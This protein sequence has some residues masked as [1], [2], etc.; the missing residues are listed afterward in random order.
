MASMKG[1]RSAWAVLGVI[2]FV[3]CLAPLL[4][5]FSQLLSDPRA[6]EGVLSVLSWPRT[7][8]LL[9]RSLWLAAGT[10]AFALV[11]GVPLAVLLFSL[12]SRATGALLLVHLFPLFLPP[13]LMALGWHH[14][15]GP[16]E[17]GR[18]RSLFGPLASQWGFVVIV[19]L[20]YLPAATGLT[21]LGL[22]GVDRG[23]E[24]AALVDV[25]PYRTVTRVLLPLAAPAVALAGLV[26]F[27]L[28]LSELGVASFLRITTYQSLVLS[29]L[30]GVAFVPGQ[31][32]GLLVPLMVVGVGLLLVE[33]RLIGRGSFAS[34]G[35]SLAGRRAYDF[36]GWALPARLVLWGLALLPSLPLVGLAWRSGWA[37]VVLARGWM[38]PSLLNSFEASFWTALLAVSVGLVAGHGLARGARFAGLVDASL[39]LG[40]LVPGTVM[41]V[42]VVALW[43]HPATQFVYG[44]TAVLVFGLAS[45]T[46]ILAS[47]AVAVS[48]SHRPVSPEEA[49]L[50]VDGS[51]WRVLGRIVAPVNARWI[52]AGWLLAMVFAMRELAAVV[53]FYPPGGDPLP[54]RIFTLEANGPPRVVAGLAL[55]HVAA[56]AAVVGLGLALVAQPRRWDGTMRRARTRRST[57]RRAAQ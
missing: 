7:W 17:L 56:T 18:G 57:S 26:I 13:F 33:W 20:T 24:E 41:G 54:V 46:M 49:A 9:G 21:L 23:L 44:S 40:F 51:F 19:G 30:G 39:F 22:L 11:F 38:G 8:L 47:R 34:L 36:G 48:V 35:T 1:H 3:V 2:V 28:S 55:I 27:A 53:V 10:T 16:H 15:L 14:L 32:I 43:N 25:G 50:C 45:R 4:A 42:G 12:R 52:A 6:M 5:L 37:G 29:R 31:A